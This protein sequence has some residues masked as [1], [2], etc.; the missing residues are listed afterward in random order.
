MTVIDQD[1]K[2]DQSLIISEHRYNMNIVQTTKNEQ[3]SPMLA[4]EGLQLLY[5]LQFQSQSSVPSFQARILE[6]PNQRITPT[7]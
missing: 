4:N 6:M 5:Q 1:K 7:S 3:T 2:Q